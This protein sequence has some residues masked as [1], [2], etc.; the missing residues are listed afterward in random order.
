MKN[1]KDILFERLAD[2]EK[3][4][5]KEFEKQKAAAR[6]NEENEEAFA[7]TIKKVI[8]AGYICDVDNPKKKYGAS[9]DNFLGKPGDSCIVSV[10]EVSEEQLKKIVDELTKENGG[11][12]PWRF[13]TRKEYKKEGYLDPPTAE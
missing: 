8:R 12:D 4:F 1:L 2:Q 5:V 7:D 3:M 6:R 13:H 9:E 11:K 10:D